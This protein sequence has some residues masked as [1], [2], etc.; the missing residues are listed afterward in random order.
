[1][2]HVKLGKRH[3][4]ASDGIAGSSLL[5]VDN[6]C[7]CILNRRTSIGLPSLLITTSS[8][9]KTST[10][11]RGGCGRTAL[12]RILLQ[13]DGP[14]RRSKST[15]SASSRT[16]S[17]L[18]PLE[19]TWSKQRCASIQLSRRTGRRMPSTWSRPTSIYP[20][21]TWSFTA[22]RMIL[23]KNSTS[24]LRRAATGSVSY[25]PTASPAAGLDDAGH[26]DYFIYVV[27]LWPTGKPGPPAVLR[28]GPS[29][30]A[31]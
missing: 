8:T 26:G 2:S 23:A 12:T 5:G 24:A 6:V 28:Q 22:Q 16:R 27:D 4:E 30:W 21:A 9:C 31:G 11:T 1:V 29:P 7:R 25:V 14:T 13:L 15:G 10:L 19:M 18:E 20:T 3:S 17:Q